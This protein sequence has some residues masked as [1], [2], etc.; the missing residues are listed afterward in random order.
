[1]TVSSIL[2]IV[3]SSPLA[4]SYISNDYVLEINYN[5]S[6]LF[7]IGLLFLLNSFNKLTIYFINKFY[8]KTLVN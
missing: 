4:L 8:L 2:F 1:M 7:L 6:N 3:F 5:L